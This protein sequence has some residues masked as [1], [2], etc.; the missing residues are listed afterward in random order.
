M[1]EDKVKFIAK[2]IVD[3]GE[4]ELLALA[5]GGLRVLKGVEEAKTYN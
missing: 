4:D 1:I 2:V 3:P 5:E